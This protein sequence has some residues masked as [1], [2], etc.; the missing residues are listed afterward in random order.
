MSFFGEMK[1]VF[2]GEVSKLV[3]GLSERLDVLQGKQA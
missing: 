2:S 3:A 1:K